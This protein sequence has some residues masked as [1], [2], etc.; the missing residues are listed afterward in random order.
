MQGESQAEPDVSLLEDSAAPRSAPHQRH[1]VLVQAREHALLRVTGDRRSF[2]FFPAMV[3]AFVSIG[4]QTGFGHQVLYPN[5]T[6]CVQRNKNEAH[7]GGCGEL[8]HKIGLDF[9]PRR[10]HI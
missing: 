1:L 7:W 8:E 6:G 5:P 3:V 10:Q 9:M 2:V 4:S